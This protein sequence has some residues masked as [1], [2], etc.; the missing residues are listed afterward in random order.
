MNI[1]YDIS[2]EE[3]KLVIHEVTDKLTDINDSNAWVYTIV[4]PDDALKQFIITTIYMAGM[5]D[6]AWSD[7]LPE[8]QFRRRILRNFFGIDRRIHH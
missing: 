7:N 5:S 4:F 2:D 1:D 8:T 6:N 3:L